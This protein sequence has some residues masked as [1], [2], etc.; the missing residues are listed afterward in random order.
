MPGISHP[1]RAEQLFREGY[2]CAQS[3]AGA[4]CDTVGQDQA[5]MTSLASSFGAGFGRNREVCGAVSA[6]CMVIGLL[7]GDYPPGDE[8]K[9]RHYAV[10]RDYMDRFKAF[11]DTWICRELLNTTV[12]G[13]T[14]EKRTEAYYASRPCIALIR[15]AAEILDEMIV[16]RTDE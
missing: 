10:V 5:F 16:E 9:T 7:W 6:A 2:N 12:T 15:R 14:P 8:G 11:K 1:D 4:F 3:V 13:G